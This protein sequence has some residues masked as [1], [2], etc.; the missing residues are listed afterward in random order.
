M[1]RG[2]GGRRCLGFIEHSIWSAPGMFLNRRRGP[3]HSEGIQKSENAWRS[4][5]GMLAIRIAGTVEGRAWDYRR[6]E[7][8]DGVRVQKRAKASARTPAAPTIPRPRTEHTAANATGQA[9]LSGTRCAAQ[10]E[11]GRAGRRSARPDLAIFMDINRIAC[12]PI[13]RIAGL[14]VSQAY[15]GVNSGFCLEVLSRRPCS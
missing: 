10:I 14:P 2:N 12:N 11:N 1:H 8:A 9:P 13:R 7:R 4:R 15:L 5:H 3:A 6:H